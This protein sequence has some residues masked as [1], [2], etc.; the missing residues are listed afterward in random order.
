MD[1]MTTEQLVHAARMVRPKILIPYHYGQ[2][3]VS[4]VPRQLRPFGIEVRIRQLQ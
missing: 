1:T 2:T 4:D 3:D